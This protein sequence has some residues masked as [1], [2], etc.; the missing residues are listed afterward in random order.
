M[1]NKVNP[2]NKLTK[3]QLKGIFSGK[4]TNWKDLGGNDS[5]I[6]IV[7]SNTNPATNGMFRKNIL[8]G[9]PFA[10]EVLEQGR[11]EELRGAVET[12]P[13]AIAFGSSTIL[14]PNV[15]QIETPEISRP[16]IMV[17]KGE[18]SAKIKNLIDFINGPGKSM[19]KE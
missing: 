16:I 2:V 9:E 14:G 18:P 19:V 13:E 1:V 6:L 4:I 17:T 12:N 5:P 11:F 7:L 3:E 10:K 8:D 15:K